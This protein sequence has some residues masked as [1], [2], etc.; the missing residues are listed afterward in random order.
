M[1]D[2]SAAHP[3][4]P[5]AAELSR[6][7]K[8]HAFALG[9]DLVGIAELGPAET[10][11]VFEEWLG[12]G[13][14]GTMGYLERGAEKRRD[15][16]LPV[17]G[18]THALVV[19][20]D[21]GGKEPSG[22]IARYARGDDYHDVMESRLRE[23]HARLERDAGRAIAG[24]PYVDTGPILER[25]LARRA[26]LGWFG[27]NT[28]LL[29][30]QLGS[31]FF[32]GALVLDAAL[33]VDAPFEE[34]RCGTCTRCIDACPTDA[35]VA[36]RR[37]DA[38]RCISYLTIELKGEIPAELR[39][40][41]GELIYGCDI[42]QEVCP[43]NV[44]FARYAPYKSP[45][46]PRAAIAGKDARTLARELLATTQDEFSRA[47]NKSPMKRAK[48]RGLQ[49][50][51]AVV[52]GNIGTADDVGLLERVCAEEPDEMVREH[53]AWALGRIG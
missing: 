29:N 32:L 53:A 49:R 1:I 20:L 33:L 40:P 21:Y 3:V 44:T 36:P 12:A 28:N 46:Q 24:K 18:T 15:T 22:P 25:D 2:A 9:F 16:R 38:R 8:A 26:G 51:A 27:K 7:A 4:A 45:F 23:V 41:I 52:L 17:P 10:S 47:F 6:L 37:L 39:E 48:L 19:A 31:F 11:A 50:N 42:C 34:D 13:L 14:G 35:I 43:W 5:D 30:P